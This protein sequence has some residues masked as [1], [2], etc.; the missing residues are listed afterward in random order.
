MK[1]N[2]EIK[3]EHVAD[4]S[5]MMRAIHPGNISDSLAP[6]LLHLLLV[7]WFLRL[8]LSQTEV[9][10]SICYACHQQLQLE[11]RLEPLPL[12]TKQKQHIHTPITHPYLHL[13]SSSFTD[14]LSNMVLLPY[15]C[16][17]TCIRAGPALELWYNPH[18][19]FLV[20]MDLASSVNSKDCALW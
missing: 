16:T 7:C 3:K 10:L 2:L 19:S 6:S 15:P 12:S 5:K 18:P 17:C 1:K 11:L 20:T 13:L 14:F 4:S 8:G 9:V